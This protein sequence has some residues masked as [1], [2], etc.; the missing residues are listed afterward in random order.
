MSKTRAIG[1]A[2]ETAV[3]RVFQELGFAEAERNVLN[4][5][6][7]DI[8]NMPI[9]IECKNHRKMELAEWIDQ[10]NRSGERTGLLSA[11]VHKRRGKHA[12]KS[13]VTMELDQFIQLL[14]AYDYTHG[15]FNE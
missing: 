3:V 10:A 9:V 11:V 4:S 2:F 13:Y 14:A 12:R 15:D 1:T 8:K 6:N 7:G 5:P